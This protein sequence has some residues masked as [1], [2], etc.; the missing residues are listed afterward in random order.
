MH[1]VFDIA[2][3][4]TNQREGGLVLSDVKTDRGGQTFGGIARR[5]W[6]NWEGWPLIDDG[7]R[8]SLALADMH[9]TFFRVEFWERPGIARIPHQGIANRVYDAGVNCGT[10]A[11]S[12]WLQRALN[13]TNL[14]GNLW[15]DVKV[16]GDIG[17]QTCDAVR[18]AAGIPARRW[19]LMECFSTQQEWHYFNIAMS[20]P[21]QEANLLGWY[22][23]RIAS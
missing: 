4:A 14:R 23:H 19:L 2:Y 10:A 11:A 13:V 7:D 5:R 8:G 1:A 15:P 16:D 9:K 18:I 22:R 12:L 3:Q 21:T 6:P 17:P 20:D